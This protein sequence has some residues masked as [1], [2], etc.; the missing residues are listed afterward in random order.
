MIIECNSLSSMWKKL[1][2]FLGLSFEVIDRI[3]KDN[4]RD[5]TAWWNP[6]ILIRAWPPLGNVG[7]GLYRGMALSK[8]Y[9]P[10]YSSKWQ[11]NQSCGHSIERVAAQQNG[12]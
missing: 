6:S 4:N 3:K 2:G 5:S 7:F 1:S 11:C 10:K 8:G 12:H 9:C